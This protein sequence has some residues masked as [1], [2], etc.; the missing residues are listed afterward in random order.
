MDETIKLSCNQKTIKKKIV[1]KYNKKD[2]QI[3]KK[4]EKK[5]CR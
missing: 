3:I 4:L 5:D 1:I 2:L